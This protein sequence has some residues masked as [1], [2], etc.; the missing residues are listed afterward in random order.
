MSTNISG[1]VVGYSTLFPNHY[2]L[3]TVIPKPVVTELNLKDGDRLR[4]C[5]GSGNTI[6]VVPEHD[7]APPQAE[8]Q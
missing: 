5:R 3:L 2:S 6:I 4:F 7:N 8:S 1:F